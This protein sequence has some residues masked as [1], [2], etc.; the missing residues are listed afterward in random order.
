MRCPGR[1]LSGLFPSVAILGD[2]GHGSEETGR[3]CW[4]AASP[5]QGSR[6]DRSVS[7]GIV[8]IT[9][10]PFLLVGA[11]NSAANAY[12]T[13]SDTNSVRVI[14]L[15]PRMAPHWDCLNFDE[16]LRSM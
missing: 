7:V 12:F 3:R 11:S 6:D 14:F 5:W 4:P 9:R 13:E 8:H 16:E 2:V 15:L 10:L 1:G